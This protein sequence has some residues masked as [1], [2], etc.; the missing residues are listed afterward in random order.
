MAKNPDLKQ[1]EKIIDKNISKINTLKDIGISPSKFK[2][3]AKEIIAR[4]VN[5]YAAKKMD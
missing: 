5:D 4:K 3:E 2:D 1:F